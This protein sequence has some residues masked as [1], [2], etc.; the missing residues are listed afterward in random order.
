MNAWTFVS[1]VVVVLIA[2]FL[3]W[4][5][6]LGGAASRRTA[7]AST[8]APV[9]VEVHPADSPQ[10][11]SVAL[12]DL[13]D[14]SEAE[15][16][17]ARPANEALMRG[18]EVSV[19][20]LQT[21]AELELLTM[22]YLAQIGEWMGY[23]AKYGALRA[24]ERFFV[25]TTKLADRVEHVA[26]YALEGV[27]A[28]ARVSMLIDDVLFMRNLSVCFHPVWWTKGARPDDAA[29]VALLDRLAAVMNESVTATSGD[30]PAA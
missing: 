28:L 18:Q 2:F 11:V 7:E 22:R 10:R 6:S 29:L 4:I 13:S 1:A 26:Q 9:M 23:A 20:A 19:A 16:G 25:Y 15:P 14:L 17:W 21:V 24:D 8:T 27:P 12:P 3:I 5:Q 30:S